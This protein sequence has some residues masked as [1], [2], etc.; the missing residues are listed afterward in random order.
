VGAITIDAAG[1]TATLVTQETWEN[2]E[3]DAVA[4]STATVR[5]TYTLRRANAQAPWRIYDATSTIL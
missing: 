2:Q 3:T 1:T 5:V 4:P